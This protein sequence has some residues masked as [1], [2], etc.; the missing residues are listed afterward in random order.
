MVYFSLGLGLIR[1]RVQKGFSFAC[2]IIKGP[3]LQESHSYTLV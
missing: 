1:V 2:A 3:K